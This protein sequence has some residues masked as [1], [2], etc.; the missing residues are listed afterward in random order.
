LRYVTE[1]V[2]IFALRT[3]LLLKVR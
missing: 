2:H 1:H 3:W